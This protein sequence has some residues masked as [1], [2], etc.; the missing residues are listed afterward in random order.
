MFAQSTL[1]MLDT[2]ARL[3]SF[4]AAAA[5]LHKV[6]SAI[7]YGVR[8][9][10]Q[11]LGVVLFERQARQVVLTPAG[12]H[13]LT[14]VRQWLRELEQVRR[15]TQRVANG[16][17]R[18]LNLALD[19]IV[20]ADRVTALVHDFYTAFDDAELVISMEVFNGVWDALSD[21]RADIAI[22][23][24]TAIPV[25]G[26]FGLREMGSLDWA[27]VMAPAH[28][29][30][31]LTELTEAELARYPVIGLEDTARTLPKRTSWLLDNQR[32]ILV[33]DWKNA[34]ACLLDGLGIGYMPRHLARPLLAGGRLVERRFDQGLRPSPCCLAWRKEDGDNA[35]LNWLLDY[36]GD[37]DQLHR[38]WLAQ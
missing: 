17:Q 36:L 38:E 9:V 11:E 34:S 22:G 21:G 13:F 23:A 6:P 4:S 25:G 8:Q 14:Q 7:S 27:L 18:S 26:D 3:G 19:N 20:K 31:A 24:T 33:P 32:R 16:W 29:V 37:S 15:H 2:V 12:E 10:E 35:L 1:V 5:Q 30:T 28:P